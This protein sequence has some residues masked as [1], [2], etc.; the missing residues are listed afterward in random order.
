MFRYMHLY[1]KHVPVDTNTSWE[2]HERTTKSRSTQ[3]VSTPTHFLPA[4]TVWCFQSFQLV[5]Q[6]PEQN[7]RQHQKW[8]GA[9]Q[10]TTSMRQREKDT[11]NHI[12]YIYIICK[13]IRIKKEQIINTSIISIARLVPDFKDL[14]V[15]HSKL[16]TLSA[17]PDQIHI[18]SENSGATR[19]PWNDDN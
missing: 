7:Q 14:Q 5:I 4:L 15:L 6:I 9:P 13:Y 18:G 8:M 19:T 3:H 17:H 10:D 16:T 1:A 2:E 12:S 11:H